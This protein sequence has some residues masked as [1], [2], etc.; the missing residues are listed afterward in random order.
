MHV[1][2]IS[3]GRLLE[4]KKATGREKDLLDFQKLNKVFKK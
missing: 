4:N 2:F 1:N 3:I